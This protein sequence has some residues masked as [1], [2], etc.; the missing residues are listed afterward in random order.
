MDEAALDLLVR[1]VHVPRLASKED[2]SR[3]RGIDGK[4]AALEKTMKSVKMSD[5]R[6]KSFTR[7]MSTPLPG[8][9]LVPF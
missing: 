3:L 6:A 2:K 5:F 1:A 4:V 9:H 7:T 8:C